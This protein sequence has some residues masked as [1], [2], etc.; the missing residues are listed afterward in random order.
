LGRHLIAIG[1]TDARYVD[2]PAAEGFSAIDA[3]AKKDDLERSQKA[4]ASQIDIG[5]I[6]QFSVPCAA[7]T[8]AHEHLFKQSEAKLANLRGIKIRVRLLYI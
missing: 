6:V 8:E 1:G 5:P 4:F 3:P 2:K 7:K